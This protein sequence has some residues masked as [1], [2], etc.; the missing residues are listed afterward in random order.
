MNEKLKRVIAI[1]ALVFVGV[2]SIAL[3]AYLFDSTLF[4]GAIGVC[5]LF[6]GAVGLALYAV[7]WISTRG[8]RSSGAPVPK[9][10]D[11][12][13]ADENADVPEAHED[14]DRNEEK[15]D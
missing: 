8:E 6:F 15:H 13:P 4:N 5:A 7:L 2:F 3:V 9:P 11:E 14:E 12:E 1:I 10:D